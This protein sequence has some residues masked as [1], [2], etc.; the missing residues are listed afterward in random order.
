MVRVDSINMDYLT[1]KQ[2]S[3]PSI[4]SGHSPVD[5]CFFQYVDNIIEMADFTYTC[6]LLHSIS[7]SQ[8][9]LQIIILLCEY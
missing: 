3:L 2:A 8:F 1:G 6:E 4:P 7:C 5:V 9:S